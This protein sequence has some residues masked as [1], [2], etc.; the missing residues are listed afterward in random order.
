MSEWI[1]V[2]NKFEV[3]VSQSKKLTEGV[4]LWV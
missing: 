2:D 4:V 1:S 3:Y